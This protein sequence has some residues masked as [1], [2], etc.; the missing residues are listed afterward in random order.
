MPVCQHSC[1]LST[2]VALAVVVSSTIATILILWLVTCNSDIRGV[3]GDLPVVNVGSAVALV[4]VLTVDGSDIGAV[5]SVS[6][7]VVVVPSLAV[8]APR[9]WQWRWRRRGGGSGVN[10]GG[11]GVGVRGSSGSKLPF[12]FGSSTSSTL[13]SSPKTV[14]P[15]KSF[16][17]RD[18]RMSLPCHYHVITMSLPC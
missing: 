7:T 5:L 17:V 13:H 3:F 12:S 1:H 4:A 6:M 18:P 8:V 10:D 15:R 11:S 16:R 14:L 9:R 2:T